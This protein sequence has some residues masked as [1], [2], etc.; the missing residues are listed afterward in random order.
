MNPGIS[1]A[2][3]RLRSS[4]HDFIRFFWTQVDPVPFCDG[5][6]IS[7]MCQYLEA[8]TGKLVPRF[9]CN[10]PPGHQKSLTVSVFWPAWVWATDQTA[11][12]MCT[13]YNRD[14][15]LRDSERCRNLIK[16]PI[17]QSLFP[18]VQI[19]RTQDTKTRFNL[20]S[21]GGKPAG[22][23][24]S[25]AV[26]SMM[27]LGGDIIVL[28]DPHSL[29]E[30]ESDNVRDEAVRK[31][32]LALFTR[33]RS[34]QA[35][36]VTIAQRLH[37]RDFCGAMLERGGTVHLCL[38]ARYEPD[39]PFVSEP[40]TL[41]DGSVLP[42]DHRTEPGELLFPT[43][44][45]EARVKEQELDLGEYGTAGQLQ[46][47]PAPRGGGLFKEGWLQR[48]MTSRELPSQRTRVRGWD[49]ASSKAK[50]A[51]YTAGVLI[52]KTRKGEFIVE[53]VRRD[54]LAPHEVEEFILKAA[55]ADGLGTIQALPQ[56]PGSAGKS[57]LLYLT[58]ALAG[59][60]VRSSPESGSKFSRAEPFSSQ[61]Y[62][63]NVVLV[64]GKWNLP[65]VNELTTFPFGKFADQVDGSSRGFSELTIM[66]SG[67]RRGTAPGMW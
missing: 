35:A 59:H 12:F 48:R 57:L 53:D 28:D 63:G 66:G 56:D 40:V 39:H 38:P 33:T 43:L 15:S 20:V 18:E 8:V 2:R 4:L 19:S 25:A 10:I 32:R 61:A 30:A 5:P 34:K 65:Y 11:R 31:L 23:R 62:Q 44:F 55:H 27:G 1:L 9:L 7:L 29:D 49:L 45:D 46:Q 54:R 42:G 58:R 21:S 36:I 50:G 64:A 13:A 41:P 37:E 22:H 47:R 14:L 60:V 16:S 26:G 17:Y 6:H 67:P 3:F 52:S 24:I 51:A